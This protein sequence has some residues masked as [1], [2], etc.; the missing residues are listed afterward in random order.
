MRVVIASDSFK[1]SLSAQAVCE[2][3]ASGVREV[4]PDAEVTLCPMADGGEGTVEALV[5]ATGGRMLSTEVLGP[6]GEPIVAAWGMLGGTPPIAAIE[7]AAASG[8]PIVPRSRR[9]PLLTTTYGTGQL[10]SAALDYGADQIILGIGGSAT[11]DGGTGCAQAVGVRFLDAK[12]QELPSGL[13]GGMLERIGAIDASSLDSRLAGCQ[14]QV[15]CDVDN[16]LCG[17]RGAAAVYSPQKGATPEMVERLDAGLAH[18][19]DVIA[20][21]LGRDVR[22][23]AGAGAAGGL[24]AGLVAFLDAALRPG[25]EI[26]TEAVGLPERMKGADLVITGEGRLDAQSMMGKVVQGVGKAALAQGVPVIAICGS[27]GPGAEKSLEL[28]RAYFSIVDKPM[29]LEQALSDAG[30]LLRETAANVMRVFV[31]SARG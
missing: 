16:P 10:V 8:L 23:L 26:V 25:I 6:L 27:I 2:A 14:V 22:D 19:A 17:P 1:E 4:V 21:D 20:R 11:N 3:I 5:A 9:N 15:A 28:L 7:M 13:S 31:E 29:P 30:P 18:L 12:G 24:G